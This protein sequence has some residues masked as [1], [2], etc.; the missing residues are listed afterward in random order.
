M[1]AAVRAFGRSNKGANLVEYALLVGVV[2][3]G[4]I[5][6]LGDLAGAIVSLFEPIAGGLGAILP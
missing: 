2:A 3:L 6:V 1:G 4:A 5:A